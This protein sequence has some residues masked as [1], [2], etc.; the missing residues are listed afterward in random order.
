MTLVEVQIFIAFHPAVSA[1][2]AGAVG[3]CIG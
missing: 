1:V 2:C 3:A